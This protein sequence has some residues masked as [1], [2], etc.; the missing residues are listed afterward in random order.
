L[1]V[2][3]RRQADRI[4]ADF[5]A[6]AATLERLYAELGCATHRQ[7]LERLLISPDLFAQYIGPRLRRLVDMAHSHGAKVMF[8]SC[9]AIVPPENV[10]ALIEVLQHQ[11]RAQASHPGKH[12]TS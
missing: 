10:M 4:P 8:H 9:G 2:I 5:A 1:T 7:L 12:A 3:R 11:S 6:N